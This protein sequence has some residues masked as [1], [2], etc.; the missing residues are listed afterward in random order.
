MSFS[1]DVKNEIINQ[2]GMTK[3]QR[4]ALLSGML[5]AMVTRAAAH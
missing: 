5:C 2:S 1:S 4:I 3:K